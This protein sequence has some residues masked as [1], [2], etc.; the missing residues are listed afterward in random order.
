MPVIPA[1]QETGTWKI[2]FQGQ[3]DQDFISTNR[4]AVVACACN[5]NYAGGLGRRTTVQAQPQ[6][7]YLKN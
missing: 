6:R 7:F 3:P 4:P 2:A 5:H 1:M